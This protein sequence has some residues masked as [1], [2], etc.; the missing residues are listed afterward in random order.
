MIEIYFSKIEYLDENKIDSRTITD[1]SDS[2]LVAALFVED[3]IAKNEAF[4]IIDATIQKSL[5]SD[6]YIDLFMKIQKDNGNKEVEKNNIVPLY[7]CILDMD[8]MELDEISPVKFTEDY[9]IMNEDDCIKNNKYDDSD[10]IFRTFYPAYNFDNEV[11]ILLDSLEIEKYA[12]DID[13]IASQV[14]TKKELKQLEKDEYKPDIPIPKEFLDFEE[15]YSEY[16][17]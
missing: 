8:G 15:K 9:D 3:F 6:K 5:L 10:I 16:Y 14:L 11:D 2:P 12:A 7:H 13:F 4:E 1:L 17:E